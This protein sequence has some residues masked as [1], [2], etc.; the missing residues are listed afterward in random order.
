MWT[1]RVGLHWAQVSIGIA[2]TAVITAASGKATAQK[3]A[4]P[5]VLGIGVSA[6]GLWASVPAASTRP[7]RR[8][9]RLT[10]SHS[11]TLIVNDKRAVARQIQ[12]MEACYR[13]RGMLPRGGQRSVVYTAKKTAGPEG[14][15]VRRFAW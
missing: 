9:I 3:T 4:T 12:S 1:A 14:P 15:A 10:A 6:A 11:T 13:E 2:Q 7:R 5:P 8:L